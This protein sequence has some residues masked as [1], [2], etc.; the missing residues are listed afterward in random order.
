MTEDVYR[1]LQEHLDK[2]P[3]GF[4]KADS[5]SDIRLLKHLFTPEEAKLALFLGFGWDRD[6]ESLEQI[7]KRAKATGI[8]LK[9]LERKLDIM[10]KKGSIARKR[11]G[12]KK[13]YGNAAL[14][15]GLYE[16]QVNKLSMEFIE[17][18]GKYI[19]EVWGLKANPTNYQQL[20]VIP[21]D[22]N[23]EPENVIAPYD[24]VKE[25][26][27]KSE[28]PFVKVNCICRQEKEIEGELC[29]ITKQKDNCIGFGNMAQKNSLFL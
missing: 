19:S 25:I 17:D 16:F 27:E 18:L 2:M 6:L 21:V 5:G 3:I 22:V 10:A 23:I 8:S 20:R 9:D 7:Y 24:N 1:Q 15:V 12:E 26:V 13:L 29:K 14:I 11:E 4:P 28:G